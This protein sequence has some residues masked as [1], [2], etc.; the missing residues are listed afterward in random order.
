MNAPPIEEK[1]ARVEA[2]ERQ[3]VAW[4]VRLEASPDSAQARQ[5]AQ[6]WRSAS[7]L[8]EQAWQ[9]VHK[10]MG[11]LRQ[12]ILRLPAAQSGATLH[13]LQAAAQCDGRRGAL[14]RLAALALLVAP[15]GYVAQRTLPWQRLTADHVTAV[16]ERRQWTLEDGTRLWL[17]TDS[18]VRIA[19]DDAQRLIRLDRGE[20]LLA[21]G[22]DRSS[23]LSRPL[24]V[25]TLQGLFE[26]VGTEFSVRLLP[27]RT[28]AACRLSV[29]DGAVR[30]RPASGQHSDIVATAGQ[31]Y[32]MTSAQAVTASDTGIE[33]RSWTE[34]LLV[35]NNARLADL[36]QEIDRYRPGHL[37][38]D[39]AVADLRIS[40]TYRL[41]DTTRALA[42]L[43]E[44][45]PIR[46]TMRTR[47]W[48]H[49]GLAQES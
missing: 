25:Q 40:G 47:Y 16:G 32:L 37:G 28:P 45:L 4:L 42:V 48:A 20:I 23:G 11:L 14:G 18:A 39:D 12:D 9:S 8:H 26:P 29:M 19:F 31:T 36:L 38:W 2:A 1:R 46:L 3:A 13:A 33:A 43:A 27:T 35:A 5:A 49:L 34:G 21:T 44:A 30:M 6:A 10:S 17:N 22:A 41:D 15:A 24:R 7:V